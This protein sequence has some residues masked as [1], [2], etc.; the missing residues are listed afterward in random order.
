MVPSRLWI[1][2][3]ALYLL[4]S[5][6]A[7]LM[8]VSWRRCFEVIRLLP[9]RLTAQPSPY[10]TTCWCQDRP[11]WPWRMLFKKTSTSSLKM[12]VQDPDGLFL[13]I[14]HFLIFPKIQFSTTYV[15]CKLSQ[16]SLFLSR[17]CGMAR[18][19]HRLQTK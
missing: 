4:A 18:G 14:L 9:S 2:T 17:K 5:R 15:R 13:G 19:G 6:L 8:A 1:M 12:S 11:L 7:L 10:G 3:S 16:Y